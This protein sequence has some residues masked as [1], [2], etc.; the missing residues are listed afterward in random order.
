ML[1]IRQLFSLF[2]GW[3]LDWLKAEDEKEPMD[4][5]S[6]AS[7]KGRLLRVFQHKAH[8]IALRRDAY[9]D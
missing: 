1:L 9:R 7:V 6:W 5:K 8:E 4:T 2:V 3:A